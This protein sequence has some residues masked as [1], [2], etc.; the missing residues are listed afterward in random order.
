MKLPKQLLYALVFSVGPMM[1]APG[2]IH[3]WEMQELTFTAEN[4]YENP[5][6]EVIVWV[7]LSGPGFNKR[8]YGFW[9]GGQTFHLRLV[10]TEPGKW[11]WKSGSNPED[12]GLAGKSI[13]ELVRNIVPF[14][15]P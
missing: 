4:S 5:Y 1:A 8:I 14:S 13:P 12:P 7:D 9:D 3:P 10:A 15:K 11:T 6:T 2:V